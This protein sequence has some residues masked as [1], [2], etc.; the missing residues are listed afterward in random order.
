MK[1]KIFACV[2][3]VIIIA[4]VSIN[5]VYLDNTII[6][7]TDKIAALNLDDENA[8]QNASDI[9]DS[10]KE[11]ET[12]ISITVSHD[13]LTNIEDGFAELVGY[14]RVEDTAGAKVIKNRLINSLEHLRRLSGFNF[15]SII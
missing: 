12:Y 5:T 9:Y 3:I 15:D 11:E 2:T 4:F 14:L 8:L 7:L 1:T 10:F 13:D 6:E